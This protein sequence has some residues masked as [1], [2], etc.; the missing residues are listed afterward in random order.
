MWDLNP[1]LSPS[2]SWFSLGLTWSCSQASSPG[3]VRW[4][5]T[6]L[7]VPTQIQGLGE[8]ELVLWPFHTT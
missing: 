4:G 3:A 6:D 2:V 5:P 8:A 1:G 7:Y